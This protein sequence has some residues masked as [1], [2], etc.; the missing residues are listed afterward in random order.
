MGEVYRADDLKLSQA[1]ALKFLPPDLPHESELLAKLHS[2]VRLGRQ[3]AHPNVCRIYDIAEWNGIHF[4]AMEYVDGEDLARLLRRIGRLPHDKATEVARGVAAGLS[5]AHAKGILHR[6][7]KPANIMIDGH[8]EARI[9]DFGLALTHDTKTAEIAGTPAYM[10]PEQLLGRP[11]SVASDVYALGL[12]M[13]EI[14]TGR[15]LYTGH[16]ITDLRRQQEREVPAPSTYVR[17][18]DPS[19]ERTI[20]RC[21]NRDPGQRPQSAREVY[22]SLPGADALAAALAAGETPSPRAVA[23]AGVEG[24]LSRTQAWSLLALIV[25]LM[26]ILLPA[27]T[28]IALIA[29]VPFD[30]PPAVLEQRAVDVVTSLGLPA[31][32]YRVSGFD[33]Q[34]NYIVWAGDRDSSPARWNQLRHGP[35]ALTFWTRLSP[36]PLTPRGLYPHASYDEPPA[37]VSGGADI[38]IDT[39]GRLFALRALSG[40]PAPSPAA[41]TDWN[42][43]LAQAGLDAA[44]LRPATPRD[45]PQLFAD[46][47]AAWDGAHPDDGTPIHIEAASAHGVPVYFRITG[48]WERE[49]ASRRVIFAGSGLTLVFEL[50][51]A[52]ITVAALL[53]AGRNLR[54]RRGDRRGAFRLSVA[55]FLVEWVCFM[56]A[57]DHH[58]DVQH[59]ISRLTTGTASALLYAFSF[60]VLYIALEPYVRRRWPERLIAWNR[61][62][63][64]NWRDPMVARDVLIGIAAGLG[65]ATIAAM[66]PVVVKFF[67]LHPPMAPHP[68]DPRT[69]LGTRFAVENMIES[70]DGGISSGLALMVL[71]V[72]FTIVLRRRSL[73]T[74]ALFLLIAGALAVAYHGDLK[75]IP[76]GI[77]IAALITFVTVR[78][79]LLAVAVLQ[80]VFECT[81]PYPLALDLPAWTLPTVAVPL[82]IIAVLS[83]WAFRTALGSQTILSGALLDED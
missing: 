17:D 10:A 42:K 49:D 24:S 78:F 26:A 57:T 71:L 66:T 7:L 68:F 43:L 50:I 67:H 56:L 6:D 47:H 46:A 54:R 35:P 62:L 9:T 8:G 38:Q 25:V 82:V 39:T 61:L 79:G 14:F 37:N 13:Y 2:E 36:A 81:F 18:L 80:F 55:V 59:E 20:T 1:V 72:M 16:D 52:L 76:F 60:W 12:V 34:R 27:H 83:L 44:K 69:F 51:V 40:A 75:L 31:A 22:E 63:A 33:T 41:H 30:K 15:R 19:I 23:A 45:A 5:A 21:L 3:V 53:L 28:T 32:R 77:A 11:A 48:S 64:G 4:V 73:G 29:M 58:A 70:I 74:A 65:H